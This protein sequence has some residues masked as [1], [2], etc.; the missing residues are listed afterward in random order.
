MKEE[1]KSGYV[2]GV[3]SSIASLIFI[4]VAINSGWNLAGQVLVIFG[5][6]FG[7]LVIGS[8]WKPETF[9]LVVSQILEDIRNT[10]EQN[11]RTYKQSQQQSR[12]SPHG[13]TEKGNVTINQKF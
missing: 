2:A 4:I 6:V 7:I 8:F 10:E 9:G 5:V 11:T 3:I 13:Y 12:N 1:T